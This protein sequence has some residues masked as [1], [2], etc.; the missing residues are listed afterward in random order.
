ML[1]LVAPVSFDCV[2]RSRCK[3][4]LNPVVVCIIIVALPSLLSPII[5]P[6]FVRYPAGLK[7]T[8]YV[9]THAHTFPRLIRIPEMNRSLKRLQAPVSLLPVVPFHLLPSQPIGSHYYQWVFLFLFSFQPTGRTTGTDLRSR[10]RC[11][12]SHRRHRTSRPSP[13]R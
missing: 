4:L 1:F 7:E 9:P 6:I 11:T 13:T 2:L 8:Y 5:K 10:R 3:L 12:I